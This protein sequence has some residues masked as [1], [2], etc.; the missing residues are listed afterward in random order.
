MTKKRPRGRPSQG[1]TEHLEVM[2]TPAEKRRFSAAARRNGLSMS[3][4][5]RL[6]L[7]ACSAQPPDRDSREIR[8][9]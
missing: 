9:K 2:L 1:R 4:W 6:C 8:L 5:V 7:C 3:D